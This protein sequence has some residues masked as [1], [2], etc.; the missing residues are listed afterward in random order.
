[1]SVGL[2]LRIAGKT[3]GRSAA[4]L[5]RIAS[6][7]AGRSLRPVARGP[8]GGERGRRT[9]RSLG[10]RFSANPRGR[11]D[12]AGLGSASPCG[13]P[14]QRDAVR[15]HGSGGHSP[16][17]VRE[18]GNIACRFSAATHVRPRDRLRGAHR[19]PATR[20]SRCSARAPYSGCDVLQRGARSDGLEG[21]ELATREF[22]HAAPQGDLLDA[23]DFATEPVTMRRARVCRSW[24][25]RTR[26][27]PCPA[28]PQR[29]PPRTA[30]GVRLPA[31]R[32]AAACHSRSMA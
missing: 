3:A 8:V 20:R 2:R 32:A 27:R 28:P 29:K 23:A 11:T 21:T 24:R 10:R 6:C 30:P 9:S 4:A 15:R 12:A 18:N 31:H 17:D 14:N 5:L 22:P 25:L 1:M 7:R 26:L 16:A 13:P 19:T